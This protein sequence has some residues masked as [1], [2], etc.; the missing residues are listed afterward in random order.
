VWP[1]GTDTIQAIAVHNGFLIIFGRRS[2]LVY[3]NAAIPASLSLQ[4]TIAGLGC[5]G[6]QTVQSTGADLLFVSD[7]GL[8]AL[9]R[10]VQE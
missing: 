1:D 4:D 9:S 8:R 6:Q 2:I 5:I 3:A 10:V 7:S